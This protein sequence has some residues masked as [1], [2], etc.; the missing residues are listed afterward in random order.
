MPID[1]A[2][3]ERIKANDPTLVELH[4]TYQNLNDSDIQPLAEA[5]AQNTTLTTLNLN[6]NQIGDSGANSIAQALQVNTSLT[7]LYLYGNQIGA[8]GAN[9]IAQALKVNTSS[10]TTL[11]LSGN[12]IGEKLKKTLEQAL[13]HNREQ[14]KR[15]IM[16][17]RD[18][19]I[20]A[21]IMLGRDGAKTNKHSF[22]SWLPKELMLHIIS[23]IDFRSPKSIGKSAQQIYQCAAFIFNHIPQLNKSLAESI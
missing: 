17:R 15:Q 12:Q 3:L 14:K 5:L 23:F 20:R 21:L 19:F 16:Q 8:I 10:L 18:Q 13:E 6:S 1:A 9:S 2:L 7:T 4:L 22:W 11:Q